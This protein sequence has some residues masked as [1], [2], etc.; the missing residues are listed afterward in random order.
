MPPHRATKAP[1]VNAC[2]EGR[3][4]AGARVIPSIVRPRARLYPLLGRVL[5][6]GPSESRLR[7]VHRRLPPC[8]CVALPQLYVARARH[9]VQAAPHRAAGRSP[10]EQVSGP[11]PL[12]ANPAASWRCT[13]CIVASSRNDSSSIITSSPISRL[14]QPREPHHTVPSVAGSERRGRRGTRT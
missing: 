5:A 12:V 7:R 6:L 2:G 8:G 10:N 4:N 9:P 3:P 1:Y 13:P 14:L 11:T